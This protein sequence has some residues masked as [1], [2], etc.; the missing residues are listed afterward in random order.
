MLSLVADGKEMGLQEVIGAVEAQE[1]GQR[2]QGLLTGN[3]GLNRMLEQ[4]NWQEL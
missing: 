3:A 1:I 4:S 2:S